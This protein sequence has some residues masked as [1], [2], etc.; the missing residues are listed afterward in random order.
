MKYSYTK[1][2]VDLMHQALGEKLDLILVQTTKHNT[3]LS[4]IEKW[5]YTLSGAILIFGLLEFDKITDLF[6]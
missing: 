2:E 1:S 5:I 3:R 6:I 4:K